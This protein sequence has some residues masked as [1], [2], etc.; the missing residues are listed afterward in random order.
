MGTGF[1]NIKTLKE[2]VD[3]SFFSYFEWQEMRNGR[4][5]KDANDIDF[6]SLLFIL[7]HNT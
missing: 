7:L 6:E 4:K 5:L 2:K 1:D 3:T